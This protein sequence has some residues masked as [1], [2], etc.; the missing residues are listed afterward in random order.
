[1]S[2]YQL[3][4]FGDIVNAICE[5]CGISSSD[6]TDRNRVKRAINIVYQNIAGRKRWWWLNQR[7]DITVPAYT[8]AGTA[9]VTQNSA[10]VTL[11][12]APTSSKK[13]YWFAIDGYNEIYRIE[14]HTASSTTVKLSG[15][16]TG[17]TTPTATYKIW[18]ERLPLPTDCKETVEVWH[19]NY[20]KPVENVGRQEFRRIWTLQPRNEGFP[21]YYYTGDYLDPAQT[22]SITA[23]PNVSTRASAGTRKTLV[24]ANSLPAAVVSTITD[25][26]P[27]V[28]NISNAGH[29]S[30][31][32]NVY[33]SAVSTTTVSNDTV[34]YTGVSEYTESATSDSSMAVA[35]LDPAQDYDR[36]RELFVYPALYNANTTLHVEYVRQATPL[37]NDDDE[38]YIPIHDRDVL[39][40]GGL[41][42][43]WKR[44]RNKEEADAS[45]QEY[46]EKLSE[47]ESKYQ[48]STENARLEPSKMYLGAK[49]NM[50]RKRSIDDNWGPLSGGGGSAGQNVTGTASRAAQFGTDGTLAASA[51][52]STELGY[53]SGVTS[54]IQTQIDGKMTS[55][56]SNGKIFVGNASNVA[57]AVTPSGDA[58]ISNAGVVAITS[59]V[60]V[61]ADVNS[62][63]GIGRTKL[64]SG[65]ADH[66]V[67]N[68]GSGLMSSE[69]TLSKV[70]GGT[71]QDNSSVTF[72]SSG[73]VQATTPNNH[74]ILVSGAGA[75]ATVVAPDASTTKVLVSGGASADPAWGSVALGSAVSGTLP[76]ANGGTN[77]GTTLNNNRVMKSSGG[78]IVE[79]TAITANRAL[80]SDANGI[81]VHSSVTDTE[82]GYVSGVTSAV[83]TQLDAKVAK[84]LTSVTGDMIYASSANTP[85]RLP[86]GSGGQFLKV[87]GGVPTW[88]PGA[89]GINYLSANPDGETDT[90]GWTTFAAAASATPDG[91]FAGSPQ[92][93]LWIRN[94]TAP[95]RGTGDLQFSKTGTASRQ[96]QGAYYSFTLDKAD[97]AKP[98][99]I[100]FDYCIT[101][102]TYADGD[103]TVYMYDGTNV[104][105]PTP[106]RIL[107]ATA[108]MPQKWIGYFQTSATATSYK[109]FIYCASTNAV[110]YKVQFDNFNVGPTYQSYGAVQTDWQAFT[111][112]GSWVSN[113]TYTG[114]WRRRGDSIDL[115]YQVAV[116]GTPTTA[117]L[118]L[119]TPSGVTLDTTKLLSNNTFQQFGFVRGIS[120]GNSFVGNLSLNS[121]TSFVPTYTLD[122]AT[123]SIMKAGN[124]TQA[125]P[126]TFANADHIEVFA[127]DIPVSGW[128]SNVQVSSDA[129]TRVVSFQG[130]KSGTQAV[131]ANVTDITVV[132]AKDSHSGWSGSAYTVPVPG[133]YVLS[134]AFANNAAAT[135]NVMA[136]KTG[137]LVG[138]IGSGTAS[139]YGGGSIIIP[140][141]KAGDTISV[142]ADSTI[143]VFGTGQ[144]SISRLSGPAQIAASEKVYL[145]YTNNGGTALTADTTNIDW[146]TKV[147]DSHGAWGVSNTTFTAP[148][149]GFYLF[150]GNFR[151]TAGVTAAVS[152]YVNGTIKLTPTDNASKTF[153]PFAGAYYLN[154]GDLVTFRSDTN[155]TLS[156]TSGAQQSFIIISSQ[157]GI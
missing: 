57:T 63:A 44:K 16:F 29:P 61:D 22:S 56:L 28:W 154:A 104:I 93:S 21:Q 129:D 133:D 7:C 144:I 24:F 26:D 117:T 85:A 35:Q 81:P 96:G 99:C 138:P 79:A 89:S 43:T 74:G 152:L 113:A 70:R 38:P 146:T 130:A 121:S 30:Y 50:M 6:T 15:V 106:Y 145:L 20:R 4:T 55:A 87:A 97:L 42:K 148:R 123:A 67:I 60:I 142:R 103:L 82:L 83:Q 147:V 116:T 25:G 98:I 76:V 128:S 37:T 49:R 109:F 65:T 64:A 54:A 115:Q 157:G 119:N 73:T 132:S 86:V 5:E 151:T 143:T 131:T 135:I 59:D 105:Q 13:N 110:D 12:V 141:C 46:V 66:V 100:S 39:Y 125:A 78:A 8:N 80:A 140:N 77:S 137:T 118:T 51:V 10:T 34:T 3:K 33:I 36:Y 72:P 17:T 1:M 69:A 58:T 122:G 48:D 32:G 14:S 9:S 41:W 111:P 91:T 126:Y 52:T 19:D 11:T 62:S 112:T 68:N 153:H 47:M 27:I 124:I 95:L 40:Y 23:L 120:A 90:T 149:A 102:G 127:Y 108:G 136:Y 2:V 18:C 45:G 101:S 31:N 53:V 150:Q 114:F 71:A 155:C 88:G 94:T 139:T 134:A 75:N 156:N 92:S 107:S 84:T